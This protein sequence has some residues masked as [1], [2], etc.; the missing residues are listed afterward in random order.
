M[1][2]LQDDYG[3]PDYF[4]SPGPVAGADSGGAE[5]GDDDSGNPDVKLG[6]TIGQSRFRP[7]APLGNPKIIRCG[8]HAGSAAAHAHAATSWT[9]SRPP[10]LPHQLRLHGAH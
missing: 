2:K 8:R 10:A 7:G 6:G 4:R 3:S 9:S 5:D 1:V